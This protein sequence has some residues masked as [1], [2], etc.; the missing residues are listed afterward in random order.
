MSKIHTDKF[1][2]FTS[3]PW[4]IHLLKEFVHI[5]LRFLFVE[6]NDKIQE[7]LYKVI[8]IQSNQVVFGQS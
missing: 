4:N 6:P 8:F 3:F 5:K 2:T 7:L 1:I